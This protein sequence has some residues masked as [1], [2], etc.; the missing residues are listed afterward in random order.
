MT[1]YAGFVIVTNDF[2]RFTHVFG[3]DMCGLVL[4][5]FAPVINRFYQVLTSLHR[6]LHLFGQVITVL[7]CFVNVLP[8][9]KS[10]SHILHSFGPVFIR[11][12]Q[13]NIGVERFRSFWTCS[14][15]DAPI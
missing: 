8:S 2:D 4:I 1:R 5:R 15:S 3:F 9:F 13:L 14:T 6:F 10:C 12:K 11:C 7:E